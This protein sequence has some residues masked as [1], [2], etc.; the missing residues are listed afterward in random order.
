MGRN[1]ALKLPYVVCLAAALQV[2]AAY[3]QFDKTQSGPFWRHMVI[4]LNAGPGCTATVNGAALP[5]SAPGVTFD[6]DVARNSQIHYHMD[7]SASQRF[8]GTFTPNFPPEV[9][10]AVDNFSGFY[11]AV[12]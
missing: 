12:S 4:G 6:G 7:C 11:S 10:V 1:R 3:G 5:G 8:D 9:P 2:P